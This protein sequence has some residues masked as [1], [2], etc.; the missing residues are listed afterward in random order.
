MVV[1]PPASLAIISGASQRV[2]V[3]QTFTNTL[4]VVVRDAQ[5]LPVKGAQ[6]TFTA[7]ASG[8]SAVFTPANT[9]VATALTQTDGTAIS[10]LL[11]ANTISG[12]FNLRATVSGVV[13]PAIFPLT[14]LSVDLPIN[15]PL[16]DG[17]K[18]SNVFDS[19]QF[20]YTGPNAVQTG[21]VPGTIVPTQVAVLRGK[22]LN[23]AGNPLS[24]VK[25]T[26]LNHPEYG[27]TL[28]RA[29]GQFDMAI[30]GGGA[31]VIN[32]QLAGFLPV[33]RQLT[34]TW[35]AYANLPEVVM[36]G[37]D[38][39]ANPIS[40]TTGNSAV[41]VAQGNV[42]TDTDG[43]RQA[44][45]LFT[46]GTTASMTLP[47]GTTQTLTSLTVRATEYTVGSNGPK[48]M[49]GTL[50]TNSGYTYALEY[51][52]D[53]ALAANATSVTFSQ[54]VYHY[55]D[56]F[57]GFPVGQAV[58]SGYYDKTNASWVASDDGR[59]IKILSINS[60]GLAEVDVTGN[61]TP[62][63]GT[64]LTDLG[65]SDAERQQLATLYQPGK[66]LWRVP[67]THFTA[68]DFNWPY[69]P[70]PDAQPPD[71]SVPDPDQ[72]ETTPEDRP[73]C[74]PG[75]Q[76]D[77]QNQDL[78]EKLAITGTPYNLHYLSSRSPGRNPSYSIKIPL[79]GSKVLPTVIGA[80]INISVA[81]RTFTQS[82]SAFPNTS[83]TFTWDGKD[84]Y[85]RL[86]Q[87]R[88]PVTISIGWTFAAY[89]YGSVMGIANSSN[90]AGFYRSFGRATGGIAISFARR[91]AVL[92]LLRPAPILYMGGY[93]SGATGLGGWNL[94]INHAYDP[95]NHT[96][97]LG[98]GGRTSANAKQYSPII[99]TSAGSFTVGTGGDG[100]PASGA[101]FSNISAMT[102]APD[103]TIY[104][105]DAEFIRKIDRNGIITHFAGMDVNGGFGGAGG[106]ALLAGFDNPSGLAVGPDGSLYIAD[107]FNHRIRKIDRNGMVSTVVGNGL[108]GG[109][110][111][112]GDSGE[113][114][115]AT[116]AL[117]S[118]P[119]AIAL[120][121]DGTLYIADSG[122]RK[123]KQV[124]PDGI[125][126]TIAG[127]NGNNSD[128]SDNIPALAGFVG[129]VTTLAIGPDGSIYLNTE[130]RLVRKID[131]KG[132]I[133]TIAGQGGS[134][135][136]GIPGNQ[137]ALS[138]ITDLTFDNQGNLFIVDN[139]TCRV[140]K[141]QANGIVTTVA[142][143]DCGNAQLGDSGPAL[144]AGILAPRKVIVLPEGDF[145]VSQINDRRI[146]HVVSPLPGL[147]SSEILFPSENGSQVYIFDASGRHLRTINRLTNAP[148]YTFA[149]NAVGVLISVTDGDNNVTTIERDANNGNATAIV[150]PYGQRTS[151]SINPT[152]YLV[153]V[154]APNLNPT[155]LSYDDNG[156]LIKLVDPN[157]NIH[158]F[159]YD[160]TGRL[161]RD[162]DPL[163][164]KSLVRTT[165]GKGSYSVA[166]ST[167]SGVQTTYKEELLG[168]GDQKRTI[169][170]PDNL[171][172]VK[173]RNANGTTTEQQP[174]GMHL[175][176]TV[177]PSSDWGMLLPLQSGSLT[178]PGGISSSYNESKAVKLND[179][180]NPL[181]LITQTVTLN[182]NG[183]TYL[184][185]YDA[186]SRTFTDT[187]PT[188]RKVIYTIDNQGRTL[189]SQESNFA[190]VS[191][192]YD[193][194]G[195]LSSIS[196]GSG[197]DLRSISFSYGSDGKLASYTDALGRLTSYSYDSTGRLISKTLPNQNTVSLGYDNNSNLTTVTPS[198]KSPTNF[199][200]DGI[201]HITG[202]T[203]PGSISGGI[204][205]TY[206]ADRQLSQFKRQDGQVVNYNYD[207]AGRINSLTS[208]TG[209]GN[210]SYTYSPTT[211]Q[212]RQ[213]VAPGGVI[214][215]LDYDGA[216]LK[217]QS[218]SGPIA[219][220]VGYS[221]NNDLQLSS[222]A[223]N[224]SELAYGYNADQLIT[225][226]GSLSLNRDTENGLLSGTTLGS[227]VT[228]Q[229]YNLFG[230]VISQT[231]STGG[232]NTVNYQYTR[233]KLGQITNTTE[234]ANGQTNFYTYTYD[235]N[236][237]LSLVTKNGVSVASYVYDANGNRL[238]F[239]DAS[240]AKINYSYDAQDRLTQAG[241]ISYTY[242]ADGELATK[243]V[244]GQ[245]TTY[246]YDV[247]GKLTG[248]IL[249]DGSHLTYLLD[250][251]S[252]RVG[253]L[254][255]GVQVQSFLYGSDLQVLAE[256]DANNNLVSRFV[257]ASHVNVPD[258]L[259]KN[260]NTY[261]IVSD[262]LG[263]VRQ[264]ID[265]TTGQVVQQLDYDAFG[266]VTQ[267]TAPGF[268]PFGFA[269]GLYDRDTALV[270]FGAR[271]YDPGIGRWTS[272]DPLGF[273]GGSLNLYKYAANDPIN[274]SDPSGLAIT[275]TGFSAGGG[276]FG[277]GGQL[278]GG[279]VTD[280]GF[281]SGFY[282]SAGGGKFSGEG[283]NAGVS[284]GGGTTHSVG[285][286]G[287]PFLN[288]SAGF[289]FG[290]NYSIDGYI[291]PNNHSS[292]GGGVT[293]G[294]GVGGGIYMGA[295][296]TWI[297]DEFHIIPDIADPL[298]DW[299]YPED[300]QPAYDPLN[301]SKKYC[302]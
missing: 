109:G 243:T 291:D 143:S 138:I 17:T 175:N 263:S 52:V 62:A 29:D 183:K 79:F 67:L 64:T 43:T 294:A 174:S 281:N 31:P 4:K 270:H 215:N 46:P 9:L 71:D 301:P 160:A 166:V 206:N 141:L 61:G 187:T 213:I 150:G 273:A 237:Q 40:L 92:S 21:V 99:N 15:P 253:K 16:L 30:N 80:V 107:T 276:G 280:G 250:G 184:S 129:Y 191:Y 188:G 285:D 221:Y 204:T 212:L 255:N 112:A 214:I 116:L 265:T 135:D 53:E 103:G 216:L 105:A 114:G 182:R 210:T 249:P 28:S 228:G 230:E 242:T 94:D 121:K 88:Q 45:V 201:D 223:V 76:I 234:T 240:N 26:V 178:T 248:V 82:L 232:T 66:S 124:G 219:G 68:W 211:G 47:G 102:T 86:M 24:A 300:K 297:S 162:Q 8:A 41:Q 140:R 229:G 48:A 85:G 75:S 108:S 25:I 190:P 137:A 197:N 199:S 89:Y 157:A 167:T 20:L 13:Q 96:L 149:Y 279:L 267:D 164:G 282:F 42:M 208:S 146:R 93:T 177:S 148:I 239:T 202:Y 165:L 258:Y 117:I 235:F 278:T 217:G 290:G 130:S 56:N 70:S 5:S 225:S 128:F 196:Q 111:G 284:A 3:G 91:S 110:G 189:S 262:Q 179:P 233:N 209:S 205:R 238:S 23:Q 153:S 147:N 34:T 65:F 245:L 244:G 293:V 54:P 6:V 193:S 271:E 122:N 156:F 90:S 39:R 169:T 266:N 264:V 180:N 38:S 256:L 73:E 7:P 27:S 257:Y 261:R 100:G 133:S 198:G 252:R 247:M 113:G 134:R 104:L 151:L 259:L 272:K 145:Y 22:V 299:L 246:Q 288:T 2:N 185:N 200:Y 12:N 84:A 19:T 60:N 69:G 83:Y 207:S 132:Y 295:S 269:G 195:R 194:R 37:L 289:G 11:T 106:P 241:G 251:N 159:S 87:G 59:V 18:V 74:Q 125:I 51:S 1:G 139:A 170:G 168:N 55:V 32:Y 126:R 176:S 49:P 268:Q 44:A 142:G 95:I 277:W 50:P 120:S 254:V 36:V 101:T 123:I 171:Q 152:G 172:T 78:G 118:Y 192:V 98:N 57:I 131:P 10:P 283:L 186:S 203:P 115:L 236:G 77:C 287:G 161:I 218:W 173:N 274:F 226:V 227:V 292:F 144:A 97:Y 222:V 63:T 231:V 81:G 181:S 127:I 163:G 275:Y 298:Y 35:Q 302:K 158:S 224:G 119:S 136:D 72:S 260:G 286:F 296:N 154:A 14:N 33:Q 220:S 155:Q 58:P